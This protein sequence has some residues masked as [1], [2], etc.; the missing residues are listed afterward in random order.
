ML[1]KTEGIFYVY[2]YFLWC[3]D[4]TLVEKKLVKKKR[5]NLTI[6]FPIF[7][8]KMYLYPNRILHT[9]YYLSC[10]NL[11]QHSQLFRTSCSIHCDVCMMYDITF[12]CVVYDLLS[13]EFMSRILIICFSKLKIPL[14]SDPLHF[15][16]FTDIC[17]TK[18]SK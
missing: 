15:F 18:A 11:Q 1:F 10:S 3:M 17:R 2:I 16:Y 14:K 4:K 9:F 5:Q 13:C 7:K 8:N 6:L 12:V